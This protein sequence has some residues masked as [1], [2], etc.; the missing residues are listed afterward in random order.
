MP[1]ENLEDGPLSTSLAQRIAADCA[2]L[3]ARLAFESVT[4]TTP[5]VLACQ[6]F[7]T[8]YDTTLR[9]AFAGSRVNARCHAKTTPVQVGP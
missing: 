3:A 7:K 8:T 2:N 9:R 6:G 5:L 1:M 4:P